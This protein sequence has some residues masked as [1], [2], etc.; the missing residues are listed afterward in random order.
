MTKDLWTLSRNK[1]MLKIGMFSQ[2]K[3]SFLLK[4]YA[5]GLE[6]SVARSWKE[7]LTIFKLFS[8]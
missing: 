1:G 2:D 3:Q 5:K 8:G 6:G 7:I 4:K